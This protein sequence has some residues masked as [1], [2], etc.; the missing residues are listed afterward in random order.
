MDPNHLPVD[1]QIASTRLVVTPTEHAGLVVAFAIKH[2]TASAL[3]TFVDD[4]GAYLQVGSAVRLNRDV[5]FVLGYDGQAFLENLRSS[6][7]VTIDNGSTTCVA[8]FE[9]HPAKEKQVRV[10]PVIC[11]R[12]TM[13]L[14]STPRG[15]AQSGPDGPNLEQSNSARN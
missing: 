13:A 6:N 1:V 2:D 10:G 12:P 3:V 4:T 9:F 7:Y 11:R 15:S 14:L 5:R 8:N